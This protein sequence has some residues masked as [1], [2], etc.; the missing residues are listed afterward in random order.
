V[1]EDLPP[2]IVEAAKAIA[3]WAVE[4]N[5]LDLRLHGV[6]LT[7]DNNSTPHCITCQCNKINQEARVPDN[8]MSRSWHKDGE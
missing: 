2:H 7:I 5:V 4:E 1:S 8:K 6:R 3:I